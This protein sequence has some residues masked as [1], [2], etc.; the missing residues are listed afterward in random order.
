MIS[1][2]TQRQ[3]LSLCLFVVPHKNKWKRIIEDFIALPKFNMFFHLH[4][5]IF[6]LHVS[7][8]TNTRIN[9]FTDDYN[10]IILLI[11]YISFE[12]IKLIFMC[13]AIKCL[14]YIFRCLHLNIKRRNFIQKKNVENYIL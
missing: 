6:I 2:F 5:H 13:P 3:S 7:N 8:V 1:C 4:I 11:Y 12:E 14:R 10:Q 9:T